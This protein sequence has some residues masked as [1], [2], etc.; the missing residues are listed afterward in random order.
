MALNEL[1]RNFAAA[2]IWSGCQQMPPISPLTYVS[3]KK[4]WTG[5]QFLHVL[6]LDTVLCRCRWQ[7]AMARWQISCCL[8]NTY[9]RGAKTFIQTPKDRRSEWWDMLLARHVS[10]LSSCRSCLS[11]AISVYIWQYLIH[12]EIF[13]PLFTSSIDPKKVV[14][15]VDGFFQRHGRVSHPWITSR[16]S[17]HYMQV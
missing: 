13:E 7:E 9:H 10:L 14:G 6:T 11:F 15:S 17:N 2:C 12:F 4:W 8:A 16:G 5:I 3:K 1:L